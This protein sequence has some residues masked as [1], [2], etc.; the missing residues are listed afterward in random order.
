[1]FTDGELLQARMTREGLSAYYTEFGCAPDR[2]TPAEAWPALAA[3]L[4][5]LDVHAR[6]WCDVQAALPDLATA[7]D[8]FCSHIAHAAR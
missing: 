7:L 4:P 5:A 6:R 3:A 2:A 1:M 8:T